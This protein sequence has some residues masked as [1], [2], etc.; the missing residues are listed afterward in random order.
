MYNTISALASLATAV[1]GLWTA[2][3]ISQAVSLFFI[4]SHSMDPTLQVGDVLLVE[5]VTPRLLIE[6]SGS[7]VGDVVLFYPPQKLQEIVSRSGGRKLSDR[8]LFVKRVAAMKG[9]VVTVEAN[10]D[11]KVNHRAD[12]R[13]RD[14]CEG[15]GVESYIQPGELAL[16]PGEVAVLG[17]C[18]R[19]SIDS[20]VWGPLPTQSIVGRPLLRL[21]PLS[22]FG[23][24]PSLP[25]IDL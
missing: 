13:A 11:V 19:V 1:A 10:G 3:C 7:Q 4:P 6:G 16:E 20:R 12:G 23:S 24:I 21:W 18:A 9:D 15:P 14:L 25:V 2:F 8:D 17:D 22:R 5:K